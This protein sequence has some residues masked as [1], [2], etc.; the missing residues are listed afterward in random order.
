MFIERRF[1]DDIRP[2]ASGGPEYR[3]IVKSLRG[4]GEHRNSL[5]A[6]PLRS[7]NATLVPRN[8]DAV[9]EILDFLAEARGTANGFRLRDWSDYVAPGEIIGTGDGNVY[10]FRLVRAYGGYSR[11]ILK[12]VVGTVQVRLDGVVQSPTLYAVDPVNGLIIF[13]FAPGSGVVISASFEFD[14]PVRFTEDTVRLIML[15]YK[16]GVSE[17]I[18]FKEI[19]VREVIDLAAIDALRATL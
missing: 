4:G 12:P 15:F 6:E 19:R 14:V 16:T 2:E 7:F 3:T 8:R 13:K 11:R 10:W 9:K 1:F 18:D 5:W 17:S